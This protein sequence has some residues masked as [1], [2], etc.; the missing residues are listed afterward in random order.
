MYFRDRID[1]AQRLAAALAAY[2]GRNPLVLAIPRGAV[3]MGRIIAEALGG[4]LDVAL[5]RK[6]RAP[7][8]PEFAVGAIDESGWAFVADYAPSAGADATYLAREK[9]A[10]LA[11][12]AA[13]RAAYTPARPPIDPADRIVIVVDDGLATGATMI[14]ALHAAR[15]KRPARLVC[16]VP[17]GAPDSVRRIAAHAD[18]VVCLETPPDF[19]AVGQFYHSFPQVDDAEVTAILASAASAPEGGG[20]AP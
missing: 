5:V 1:A 7:G 20:G 17:V 18:E 11:T 15:A 3:P 13:R 2:R 14:A 16:A 19:Y 4:D 9:A 10:Q 6:L 12:L 8:Q